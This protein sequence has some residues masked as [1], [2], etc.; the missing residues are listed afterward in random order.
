VAADIRRQIADGRL[1]PGER[2][3]SARQITR[4]WGVAIATAT[5]AVALLRDEGLV[6]TV[7]GVGTVVA[8]TGPG[9]AAG[10]VAVGAGTE[11]GPSPT[12]GPR[13]RRA[14]PAAGPAP[15]REGIARAA[16]RIA[17][18]EGIAALSMRRVAADLGLATMS[19]YRY[20]R[21]KDDL[22]V[23][24]VDEVF[25]DHPP[26]EPPPPGWR[27][28]LGQLARLQWTICQAHPWLARAVSF[29]RPTMAPGG[30][31]HTEWALR[32]VSGLGLDPR[33]ALYVVLTVIAFSV[34]TAVNLESEAEAQQTTGVTSDEWMQ[35]REQEFEG[36]TASGQYPHLRA[37]AEIPGFD[38][39]LPTLFEFGLERLLDGLSAYLDPPARRRP[40]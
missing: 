33:T 38:L 34:G 29:T 35:Q 19:L 6:R 11:T 9:T 22:V 7:P 13:T 28:Q 30:M 26:A 10:G 12:P 17:D 2:V 39:E 5:R 14:E 1:S 27:A 16:I 36:I 18:A 23:L 37:L 8:A 20:V 15:S 40:R 21:S 3:P 24:M 31:A 4:D 25:R 32:A